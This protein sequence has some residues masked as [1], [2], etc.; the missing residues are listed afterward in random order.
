MTKDMFLRELAARLCQLPPDEIKRQQAYY[1]ELLDD[2]IE[3]GISEE[4]A[5]ERLGDISDIVDEILKDI[6]IQ[7]LVKSRVKPKNGWTAAAIAVAILGAPLWIPLVLATIIVAGAI[8]LSICAVII[9]LFVVVLAFGFAGLLTIFHGFGLFTFGAG[10]AIFAI[11]TGLVLLGLVFLAVLAAEYAAIGL[12][13]GTRWLFR[14]VKR[15]LFVK[16]V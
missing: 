10:Y 12:F 4:S 2:M 16:E 7:T 1:A 5:V 3:D 9:S 6:P 11:G 14:T 15:K 13:H 8:C